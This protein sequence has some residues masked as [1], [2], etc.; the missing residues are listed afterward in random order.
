M[1]IIK[2][3]LTIVLL[4]LGSSF[5][6]C[7]RQPSVKSS[8]LAPPNFPFTMVNQN[9]SIVYIAPEYYNP[10]NMHDLFLWHYKKHLG[11]RISLTMMVFTEKDLLNV[12]LEGLKRPRWESDVPLEYRRPLPTRPPSYGSRRNYHD[13]EF[14]QVPSEPSLHISK[15]DD[16]YSRGYNVTYIF[17][18]DLSRPDIK[19]EVVL[20]GA[21]WR[22]GKYNVETH[23]FPWQPGEIKLTAYDIYNVEPPSRYYTFT[24][25]RKVNNYE[26]IS[27]IFNIL[28]EETVLVNSN[29]VKIL[30]DKIA[31]VYLGWMYSVTLD[32]GKAW[33]LWD[34]E[35]NLPGWNCCDSG[36]IRD[37]NISDH[38]NG[39]MTLRPDPNKPESLIYLHTDDFGQS[40][41][42][43]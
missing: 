8:D 25:P 19:K 14:S 43:N 28:L 27:I 34:A 5:S 22:E 7:H 37:V 40:W 11:M 2:I 1:S 20:R 3:S 4:A 10:N 24:V 12:Y 13:A 33:H 36:L 15:G 9:G 18:P 35:R 39:I 17:A 32:G 30:S 16:I 42:N 31:Y 6:N 21:T 26:T 29:Q 23:V 41:R 38:G